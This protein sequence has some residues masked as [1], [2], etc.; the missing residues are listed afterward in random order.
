MMHEPAALLFASDATIAGFWGAAAF[1]AAGLTIWADNR[2][3]K[4]REFD[5]VGWVPWPKLFFVFALIGIV[6]MAMA[7]KGWVT[8]G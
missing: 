1:I 4:R 6:L 2:R 7:I 8:T 5:R 3:L